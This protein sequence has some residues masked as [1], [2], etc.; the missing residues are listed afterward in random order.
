MPDL[1]MLN[2]TK[3]LYK[4]TFIKCSYERS[5]DQKKKGETMH[6]GLLH[7]FRSLK[8]QKVISP[9]NVFSANAI[10]AFHIILVYLRTIQIPV[11]SQYTPP[12]CHLQ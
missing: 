11:S 2:S 6:P 10:F 8:P 4:L 5:F 1:K 12:L 7:A 9:Q 3:Y